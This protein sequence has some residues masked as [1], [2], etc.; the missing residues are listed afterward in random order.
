MLKT[1]SCLLVSALSMAGVAVLGDQMELNNPSFEQ[2]TGGY[3]INTPSAAVIDADISSQGKQS[4]CLQSPVS[5]VQ[6]VALRPGEVYRFSFDSKGEFDKDGPKIQLALMLQGN[7]PIMFWLPENRN[8]NDFEF[9]PTGKWNR[10]EFVF[11]PVPPQAQGQEATKIGLYINAVS[12]TKP[13][14]VWIDNLQVSSEKASPE[15]VETDG[16]NKQMELNNPSFEQGTDGYWIDPPSAAKIDANTESQGSQSLCIEPPEGK[17]ASVVQFIPLKPNMIYRFS[18]DSKGELAENGPKI[19]LA[20]MLQGKKPII[21]WL[22]ESRDKNDFEFIPT[23]K[24]N[25]KEFVFGPVPAKAQDQEVTQIGLFINAVAGAKPGKVWIDN[26]QVSSEK[27]RR[28]TTRQKKN[29]RPLT[30]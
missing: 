2:G 9:I 5:V 10:K 8:K 21:F 17:T 6:F 7:K 28:K 12:G 18:F 23:G 26:L 16:L 24:W 20:L 29:D 14:K 30:P 19:Q 1:V 13:G 25:R 11:G 27:P 15:K 3:W 22:P 4:L